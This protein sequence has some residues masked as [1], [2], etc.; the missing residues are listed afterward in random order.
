MAGASPIPPSE[1][2][3]EELGGGA[4]GGGDENSGKAGPAVAV[5]ESVAAHSP[6]PDALRASFRRLSNLLVEVSE[7]PLI[8]VHRILGACS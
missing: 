6:L 7:S 5:H 1:S 4:D 3:Q 8:A 2:L